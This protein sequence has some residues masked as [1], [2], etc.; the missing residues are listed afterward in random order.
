MQGTCWFLCFLIGLAV[1]VL[2]F[3]FNWGI[4]VLSDAKFNTTAMFISPGGSFVIP[5]FIFI[6]F[7]LLYGTVAGV[8]GSYL[9]PLACGRYVMHLHY[10]MRLVSWQSDWEVSLYPV[11]S[12]S[13]RHTLMV[14]MSRASW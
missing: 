5:F 2:A 6:A 8:C 10:H 12:L 7:S 4:Q 14:S 9:A 1:A 11:A 13:S 3:F